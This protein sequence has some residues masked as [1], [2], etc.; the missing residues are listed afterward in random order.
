MPSSH[1]TRIIALLAANG[2]SLVFCAQNAIDLWK[3][4]S[5]NAYLFGYGCLFCL[6]GIGASYVGLLFPEARLL[7]RFAELVAVFAFVLPP[8]LL[9]LW[10]RFQPFLFVAS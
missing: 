9:L 6:G 10:L 2:A 4:G 1:L 3:T 8:V 7:R 5:Q